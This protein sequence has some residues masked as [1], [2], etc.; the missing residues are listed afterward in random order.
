MIV[1]A[2]FYDS[3]I[4]SD[5]DVYIIRAV[6]KKQYRL[7]LCYI[8]SNRAIYYLW[9]KQIHLYRTSHTNVAISWQYITEQYDTCGLLGDILP[10][11]NLIFAISWSISCKLAHFLRWW[12]SWVWRIDRV[13]ISEKIFRIGKFWKFLYLV[14]MRH[15]IF[16]FWGY[17]ANIF[18]KLILDKI[19]RNFILK[20]IRIKSKKFKRNF[21]KIFFFWICQDI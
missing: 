4:V 14:T 20:F 19:C 7:L 13:E 8:P 21:E 12:L 10:L 5:S 11:I 18:E 1:W 6:T 2:Y 17:F 9:T 16:E 15:Q 3:A